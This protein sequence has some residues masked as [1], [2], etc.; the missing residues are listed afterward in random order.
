MSQVKIVTEFIDGTTHVLDVNQDVALTLKMQLISLTDIDQRRGSYSQTFALPK[1]DSNTE[2]FG[3]FGDPSTIGGNWNPRTEAPAVILEDDNIILAGILKLD[4]TDPSE[5][6]FYVS[7]SGQV[8]TIKS[9]LGESKMSS[10]DMTPWIYTPSQI[11]ST[12]S[13]SIFSGDMVFP[14]HD[15]GFG[16]GLYKKAGA[17]N[18]LQDPTTTATPIILNQTI[19]CFRLTKLLEMIFNEQGITV[20]GSFFSETSVDDIYVQADNALKVF[21]QG[22]SLFTAT[23]NTGSVALDTTTR[24]LK[25]TCSPTH[26]DFNNTTYKYTAPL[27]GTYY[28]D[29][30]FTPTQGTPASHTCFYGWYKN[31]VLSGSNINFS[32]NAAVNVTGKSFVLAAGDTLEIRVTATGG[33]VS[34]GSVGTSASY[35]WK[36]TSMVPSGVSVDPSV[37]WAGH[38]QVDFFR[39]IVQIFN[40]IPW[41]DKDGKLQLDSWNAYMA[42]EGTKKDWSEKVDIP[43]MVTKPINPEL[44]NPVNLALSPAP[45]VLNI[46]YFNAIGRPYGSYREDQNIPGTLEEQPEIKGFSPACLQ[47]IDPNNVH[48]MNLLEVFICKYYETEDS[49]AFKTPGLQL[50][51]YNGTRSVTPSLYTAD[52][53]GGATTARTVYPF[54]SNFKLSS[55]SY[56]ITAAT[57]DLNFTWWTPPIAAGNVTAPSEQ[58]LFNRY[59]REMIRERYDEGSKI[60]E[61]N[62]LLDAADIANFSFADTIIVKVNGTSVGLRIVEILDYSP[63][64]TRL[65]KIKSYI[66]FIE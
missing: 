2:F 47:E 34:P 28:F 31:G 18:V 7:I 37:Y 44:R 29:F 5:D 6:N 57:L 20:E 12:W 52:A 61:F 50:M 63:N 16:W 8:A 17:A 65:T 49:L 60:V 15:F 23:H 3:S 62:A 27:A 46:D 43:S 1:T 51:Y 14:I 33:Y 11:Y 55:P 35:Q 24:V 30:N 48:T 40:I 21:S 66:T 53:S 41:W 19:P 59:F 45:N 39:S 22:A 25:Y 64:S 10:L 4:S 58:G 13:R 9:I 56:L 38:R 54:F 26:A 36:L 32:W 42:N